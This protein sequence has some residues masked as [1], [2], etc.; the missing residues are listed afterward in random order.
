MSAW[1]FDIEQAPRGHFEPV[2]QKIGK[3]VVTT[4]K[5]VPALIIA[6]GNDGVVTASRWLPKEGRWNMFTKDAPPLAWQP[7]PEHP[8]AEGSQ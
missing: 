7:W 1:N 8:H 6:A 2:T 4:E 5:H 3:N